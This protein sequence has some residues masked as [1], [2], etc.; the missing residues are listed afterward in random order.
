LDLDRLSDIDDVFDDDFIWDR[1]G[2][3]NFVCSLNR[4]INDGDDIIRSWDVNL[5]WD[6]YINAISF[7]TGNWD[8]DVISDWDANFTNNTFDLD[9]LRYLDSVIFDVSLFTKEGFLSNNSS[10]SSSVNGI[11]TSS[12][13][14]TSGDTSSVDISVRGI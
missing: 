5:Y 10:S 3:T 9:D 4:N 13:Y 11:Y 1:N 7:D 14:S 8:W 12:S 6:R 2:G